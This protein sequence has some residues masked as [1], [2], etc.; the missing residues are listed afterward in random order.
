MSLQ[1]EIEKKKKKQ[2]ETQSQRI[3]TN[4]MS[5]GTP[6]NITQNSLERQ[7]LD[8]LKKQNKLIIKYLTEIQEKQNAREKEQKQ[9]ISNLTVETKDF[10]D[11]G[12]KVH[13]VF[14]HILKEKLDKVDID[15]LANI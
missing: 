9:L 6:S 5:T 11:N 14:T 8:E 15:E 2:N 1:D 12:V 7:E 13:N 3:Q 10:R 4:L